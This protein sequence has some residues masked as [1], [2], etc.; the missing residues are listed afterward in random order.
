MLPFLWGVSKVNS[1]GTLYI[2]I[3]SRAA[4]VGKKMEKNNV[5]HMLL[6]EKYKVC[7]LRNKIKEIT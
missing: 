7:I 2:I 5:N 1:Y 4:R 6:S 3:N